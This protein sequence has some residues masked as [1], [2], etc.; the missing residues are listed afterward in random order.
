MP[1]T[2]PFCPVGALVTFSQGLI[3]SQSCSN[4]ESSRSIQAPGEQ[5]A[6][7]NQQASPAKSRGQG[8][9]AP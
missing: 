1:W 9:W 8:K 4:Y 6:S 3:C 5:L 7:R 2:R